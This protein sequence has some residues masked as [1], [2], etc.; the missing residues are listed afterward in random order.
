MPV[1][2]GTFSATGQSDILTVTDADFTISLV[3]AGT[4]SVNLERSFDGTNWKVVNTFTASV[5]DNGKEPAS[6]VQ[7]R[8]NCTAYTDDVVYVIATKD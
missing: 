7:Y 6:K 8:F 2:S 4:A 3:F 1:V 5:E